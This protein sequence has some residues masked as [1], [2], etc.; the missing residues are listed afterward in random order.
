MLPV[1]ALRVFAGCPVRE[2]P[3]HLDM[4]KLPFRV[5]IKAADADVTDTLS[6]QAILPK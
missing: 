4:L 1:R 3:L 6:F 2:Q 5:L